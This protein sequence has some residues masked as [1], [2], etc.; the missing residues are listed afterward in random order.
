MTLK[1]I[2]DLF[3]NEVNKKDFIKKSGLSKQVVYN[4]RKRPTLGVGVMIEVLYLIGAISIS[5][6]ESTT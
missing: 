4:Y 1:E 5:K 6:N 2:E 3:K